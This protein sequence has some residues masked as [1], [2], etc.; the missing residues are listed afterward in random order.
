MLCTFYPLL[1]SY[2]N[3]GLAVE[4]LVFGGGGIAVGDGVGGADVVAA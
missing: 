4:V 1:A 3:R 2:F